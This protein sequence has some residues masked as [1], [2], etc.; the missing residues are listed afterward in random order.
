[1]SDLNAYWFLQRAASQMENAN[2]ELNRPSEDIVTMSVCQL[3]KD[4]IADLL[5]A[6]LLLHGEMTV[7]A[8]NL[9]TLRSACA[10]IEPKFNSLNF[11]SMSCHPTTLNEDKHYCLD[12]M[13]VFRCMGIAD[14]VKILVDESFRKKEKKQQSR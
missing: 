8:D 4:I 3:S 13:N 14:R 6:F 9:E 10:T 11:R 5:R 1:M 2:A 12:H 7:K